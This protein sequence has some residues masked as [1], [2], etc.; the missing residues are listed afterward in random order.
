MIGWTRNIVKTA[1]AGLGLL[2]LVVTLWKPLYRAIDMLGNLDFLH[3]NWGE[4]GKFLDS[5]MGTL[6]SVAVGAII[7]GYSI[8][9]GLQESGTNVAVP[10]P[11]ASSNRGQ[12]LITAGLVLMICGAVALVLG[13]ILFGIGK[14]YFVEQPLTIGGMKVPPSDDSRLMWDDHLG[15]TYSTEGTTVI[16]QGCCPAVC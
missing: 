14:V 13:G 2:G 4:I 5:G 8:I 11:T 15:H 16:T 12:K 3:N 1:Y 9:R 10:S 6:V 7:I